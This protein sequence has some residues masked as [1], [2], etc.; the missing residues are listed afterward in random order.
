M[1][2]LMSFATGHLL[3]GRLTDNT[4]VQGGMNKGNRMSSMISLR[5]ALKAIRSDRD[6]T[7]DSERDSLLIKNSVGG[8]ISRSFVTICV[9]GGV[10][11]G[12]LGI[13]LSQHLDRNLI[14]SW[15]PSHFVL[16]LVYGLVTAVT[17]L[18]LGPLILGLVW[19]KTTGSNSF[20]KCWS[21]TKTL[22]K[23]RGSR[24]PS[25]A[26]VEKSRLQRMLEQSEFRKQ[27]LRGDV[28]AQTNPAVLTRASSAPYM[29]TAPVAGYTMAQPYS[30][31]GTAPFNGYDVP[32]PYNM[33]VTNPV[34]NPL[35]INPLISIPQAIAI[36]SSI[37][38]R[39]TM[40]AQGL[41]IPQTRRSSNDEIPIN[42]NFCLP[43][44]ISKESLHK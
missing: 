37:S 10:V 9:L 14:V 31:R 38:R 19:D 20:S 27:V 16:F 40:T 42:K 6:S 1:L 8:Y 7:D 36:A 3:K 25:D 43:A 41:P 12:I 44:N 5:S 26:D 32:P 11:A 39:G 18:M 28:F 24:R 23:S 4:H 35:S 30:I 22:G 29:T 15:R 17:L 2:I 13:D 21:R 34:V 33:V